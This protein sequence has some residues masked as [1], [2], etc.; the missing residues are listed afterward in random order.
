MH[1]IR[2]YSGTYDEKYKIAKSRRK[3]HKQEGILG[4][5]SLYATTKDSMNRISLFRG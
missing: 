3:Y 4:R 2:I 1:Y 5:G